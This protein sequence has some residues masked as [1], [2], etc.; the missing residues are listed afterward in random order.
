MMR[1]VQAG[2]DTAAARS[3]ARLAFEH[4]GGRT[5]VGASRAT[6]PLAI[7]TPLNHGT[8]AWA[9][10]SSH[11]GGLVDGDHVSLDVRV[12]P[13]GRALLSTQGETRVYRSPRGCSF[14]LSARVETGGLLAIVPDPTTCFA[15]ATYA[16][17]V[18]VS[19]AESAQ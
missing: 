8:A 16:Q 6:S 2:P 14:E 15:G 1:A 13:A 10:L 17:H 3:R 11:G 9:Y 12:G 4:V 7:L 5:R 18:D 19:L